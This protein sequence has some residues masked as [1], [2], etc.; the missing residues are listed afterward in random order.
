MGW[1]QVSAIS[2]YRRCSA[3]LFLRPGLAS[4]PTGALYLTQRSV[5]QDNSLSVSLVPSISSS[6]SFSSRLLSLLLL[7]LL[8]LRP[9]GLWGSDLG[10]SR[11]HFLCLVVPG[12]KERDDDAFCS[13][14]TDP[15]MD[16]IPTAFLS[17]CSS[18]LRVR[19]CFLRVTAPSTCYCAPRLIGPPPIACAPFVSITLGCIPCVAIS[20]SHCC[21]PHRF[22]IVGAFACCSLWKRRWMTLVL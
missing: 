11:P 4:S 9:F 14:W 20:S 6:F 21:P 18:Q 7:L 3:A 19:V 2:Q 8:L 17:I 16:F 1:P 12:H 22:D 15:V 5:E 10:F 13:R